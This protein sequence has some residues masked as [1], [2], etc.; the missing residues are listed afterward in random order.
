M[1]IDTVWSKQRQQDI[2][3]GPGTGADLSAA[4]P[5]SLSNALFS[6]GINRI[7]INS[8]GKLSVPQ[9]TSLV[10]APAGSLKLQAGE[11]EWQGRLLAPAGDVGLKTV[12]GQTRPET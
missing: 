8:G 5:I 7:G 6:R 3:F 1:T 10:L 12:V 9:T 11:I 2:V 4:V